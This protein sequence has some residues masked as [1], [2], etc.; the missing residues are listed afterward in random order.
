MDAI[1]DIA[2][3]HNL[4]VVE[5]AAQ[6]MMAKYGGRPLGSIGHLATYS[7]HETKNYTSGGEGGLLIVNDG[8]FMARA[9]IIREKGT[10]RSQFFRGM[11]D[12]YSWVDIGS[13]YLPSDIQAAYLWGQLEMAEEINKDRI[14][15]WHRYQQGLRSLA[16]SGLVDLPTIPLQCQPNGHMFYLKTRDLAERTALLTHLA[17]ADILGVFH[18]VP[19]HSASAGL[20]FGRFQGEDRYTTSESE[21]LIRLPF[22]YGMTSGEIDSVVAAVILFYQ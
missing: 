12:K 7:F 20:Q 19:L 22:W 10:N 5:D 21:R 3:R 14:A 15:T 9:E 18:Y 17:H 13:S 16:S 4:Y 6:G 8:Q 2:R 1:M 11:A